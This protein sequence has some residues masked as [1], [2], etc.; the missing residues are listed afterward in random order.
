MPRLSILIALPLVGALIVMLCPKE[1]VKLIQGISVI[2]AA[3]TSALTVYGYAIFDRTA[4]GFQMEES[5]PWL[6]D[7]GIQYHLGVDG[8]SMPMVLLTGILTITSILVSLNIRHRHREY[9]AFAFMCLAGVFGIFESLD[10]FFF[11]LFYELASIPMY[12]LIGMWGSDKMGEGKQVK[13]ESAAIKLI[14]YL[15]LG[16]GL[17]LLA[18]LALYF[19][20]PQHTF[21]FV[22]L[23]R[24]VLS[25]ESQ[26]VL[27]PLLFIGFGIELGLVPFHTWL[28]DGHSAAPTALSMLL[29]GVLL[30][31]GGYGIIRLAFSLAPEGAKY[32]MPFFVIL[33]VINI[34]YGALCAMNQ[35]DIKYMIAYSSVSH[36]GIVVLGLGS[37]NN[38]GF[39]G[40]VY[41]LFSHGIITAMLFA[42]AGYIYEKTHT[43]VMTDHGG[44]G[45]K[46]PFLAATFGLAGMA[47]VGLP[48]LS[49]FV[50]EFLVFLSLF[51]TNMIAMIFAAFGLVL[52]AIYVL[53]AMQ[54]IFF[55]PFNEHY[56]ELED[57]KGVE[58]WPLAILGL[59]T[60]LFGVFPGLLLQVSNPAVIELVAKLGG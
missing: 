10:L 12:F 23:T 52:T 2:V 46:M 11:V 55:G 35:K 1:R 38:V 58:R 25:R 56:T 43:R 7:L 20:S 51:K 5:V 19:L 31:M 36:M 60:F 21:D 54:R 27:F 41:Q 37:F 45:P 33:G 28:P 3:A 53:R 59:T 14:L 17:V 16:G 22:Q 42:L 29:A 44:L 34:L 8:I 15:Q 50:A 6:K 49:G 4:S 30:K 13:K 47:T 18:V 9:F 48:G 26:I 24:Q 40:A 32:W 57:A 39:S